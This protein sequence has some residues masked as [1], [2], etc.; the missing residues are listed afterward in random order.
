MNSVLACGTRFNQDFL[1][2]SSLWAASRGPFFSSPRPLGSG[3]INSEI[4]YISECSLTGAFL[5]MF[6]WPPA[7]RAAWVRGRAAWVCTA[8][9]MKKAK[10][11]LS[12][13]SMLLR[14]AG[15]GAFLYFS[16]GRL[17]GEVRVCATGV[18]KIIK[19]ACPLRGGL[20][21][22]RARGLFFI[23]VWAASGEGKAGPVMGLRPLLGPPC[24]PP[25][26][27]RLGFPVSVIPRGLRGFCSGSFLAALGDLPPRRAM[28]ACAFALREKPKAICL[29]AA[30]ATLWLRPAR[31][32]KR[33][34]YCP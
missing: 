8:S 34:L 27:P 10:Q 9:T 23:L 11:G 24:I 1:W 29:P 16:L 3:Q 18:L 17:R 5:L 33:H 7:R 28:P 25:E 21:A 31:E 14:P 20:C 19:Q 26:A 12:F 2:I 32:A 13:E 22:L 15:T 6:F 4:F 30:C